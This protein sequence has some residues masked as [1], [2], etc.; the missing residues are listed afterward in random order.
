VL[1]GTRSISAL[2]SLPGLGSSG[3]LYHHLKPLLAEGWLKPAGR[4]RY[5]VPE[6]RV[7]PLLAIIATV[8]Q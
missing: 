7:V 8:R 2:A 6:H 4:G 1:R 3:Q 5:E